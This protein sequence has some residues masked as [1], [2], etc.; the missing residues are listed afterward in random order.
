[1][2][3][4]DENNN[5]RPDSKQLV[6]QWAVLCLLEIRDYSVRELAEE[7]GTSKTTIQRDL[8]TLG[9]HFMVVSS[10]AGR[11][12]RVYRLERRNPPPCVMLTGA[13]VDALRSA[14]NAAEHEES[15]ALPALLHQLKGLEAKKKLGD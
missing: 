10:A 1:M 6:R 8:A 15:Q 14:I 5:R 3:P 9:E 13:E 4:N 2:S 12:K 7:L 11:Q